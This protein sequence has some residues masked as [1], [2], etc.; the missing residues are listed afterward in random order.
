MPHI[1]GHIAPALENPYQN[2]LQSQTPQVVPP[3]SRKD[4]GLMLPICL[5]WVQAKLVL[6]HSR[7]Y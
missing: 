6:P 4:R 1:P 5:L 2:F 3:V 7:H